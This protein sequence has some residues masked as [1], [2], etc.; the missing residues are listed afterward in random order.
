MKNLNHISAD[1]KIKGSKGDEKGNCY[2]APKPFKI[3][4]HTYKD[5]WVTM[6]LSGRVSKRLEKYD[7]S[8]KILKIEG[9]NIPLSKGFH[10]GN[11]AMHIWK[12]E[13]NEC[14]QNLENIYKGSA[15][16][17]SPKNKNFGRQL[18]VNSTGRDIFFGLDV[19]SK[20]KL[21]NEIQIFETNMP[22]IKVIFGEENFIDA[23]VQSNQTSRIDDF[24]GNYF[25]T[26]W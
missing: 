15:K 6:Q 4:T 8:Q 13:S 9:D 20:G 23:A 3:G 25:K 5:N 12:K 1:V 19:R 26:I 10:K 18:I 2:H 17:I 16:I 14:V 22:N 7:I 24:V 11:S 21:C